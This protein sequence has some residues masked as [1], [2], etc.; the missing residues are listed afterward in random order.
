[1]L[2]LKSITKD[3]VTSSETVRALKGVDISFRDHEFV[4]ILGPSG[5]GKTTMLN[6]VGG[7]DKYTSGDLVI[8]GRSTKSYKDRDWDVYRNHRVGFIFQSYNLIPHQT[9]LGNVELA[10]TIAGISKEE[11]V[12]RAKRALDRVG[13]ENQYYKKPNQLSGGQCQRVAI[14]RALVNDPE[15]LLADEP[16]GALDTVTSVQIMELIREIADERLVIM[17]THNPEL[18]EEY[19]SR[20]V[21]LLDGLIIEDTNPVTDEELSAEAKLVEEKE[22]AEH[23]E[24]ARL[25]TASLKEKRAAK[26]KKEKAKMSFLTALSLS[27]KNLATKKGRTV[28][29]SFAG[30][31]GIIGIALILALS[32]GINAFI[33]QVQEDTLSTYPLAIQKHTQDMAAMLEAMTSVSDEEDYRD[34]GKIYVDDSF[35]TMMGAMSSTVENNLEAF[36]Q[37][38]DENYDEIKDYISDVQYSYDYDLQVYTPDGKV[39]V[40]METVFSHMGDAFAGMSELMEMGGSMSMGMDVFSEM[41]NNQS[42]LDQQYEVISGNWPKE[43]NEV[44]LVVNSNNQISK[45]TLYMLGMRDPENID[46]EIKDLMNGEYKSEDI[47]PFT[48]EDI[49]NM[50]FKLLT[51]SDFFAENGSTYKV[52][53]SDKT[54]PVWNDLR[55]GFGFDQE[56]FVF[57]NGIEIKIAGIVRPKEGATARSISGAIGYTKELTDYILTQNANSKVINQQKETPGVNVLTGLPFERTVYTRENIQELIDKVDSATMSAFYSYMTSFIKND[58]NISALLNVNRANINTMFMLLPEKDQAE[59]LTKIINAAYKNNPDK[60]NETFNTMSLS[61]GGIQVTKENI[62]VL[63]PVLNKM[64]TMPLVTALG[65]PGIL[66]LADSAV[67]DDVIKGINKKYPQVALTPLGEVTAENFGI[68]VGYLPEAERKDAYTKIVSSINDG[69][70]TMLSILCGMISQMTGQGGAQVNR[71]NLVE[72]LTALPSDAY[73]ISYVASSGMP[74]FVD[75]AGAEDMKTVYAD[76][77]ELIMNLEVDDKIFSLLLLAMPDEQ[78]VQMEETLYGMA[79]GIDATYD[80]VLE[81]LDDAEKAQPA[82]INF[83]A[84]DFESKEYIEEFIKGYNESAEADGR[85]GDVIKYT[86]VVG[87]MMSSVTIIIDAISYVLIAFVSI[88]LVVSSIMIG[89]IT[90][91]SVLERIK[92]IGILRA[93]GASKKDIS[94][95]FNAET[96]IIGLAAGALGILTTVILCIP[97]TAIVQYLTEIDSIRAILPWQGAVALVIVSMVLT[98]IAGIIPSRSAAKKDPVVA[99]RTE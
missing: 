95:I 6:I 2:E 42:I 98:L 53:G 8:N 73:Q 49:L 32:T 60:C 45:M 31:I 36:K 57:E 40:G 39:K 26:K 93:M 70:G 92:E 46:Q 24:A 94:R 12:K 18:A 7:L 89:I 50:R 37:Y 69:N 90:N 15:I 63:L 82:S 91:I 4:S 71:D 51:T 47:P 85:E 16:T 9:I 23:E 10:L 56:K 59:V 96:L 54:Y 84:K 75:H 64:E 61:T 81:T 34:S 3:Y 52:D 77:N 76:M 99:L 1:M 28:M 35:G 86:D 65:I 44:V 78:F 80:S 79:P 30:S 55:E 27:L 19:S 87:A 21:R 97:I 25:K 33:A 66:G 67:V 83:F 14:A 5:C 22:K 74:G 38:I 13:L 20:I 48:Y 68:V 43:Y 17:V 88:S 58:E 41:I 62:I 72:T 11:R 29:T